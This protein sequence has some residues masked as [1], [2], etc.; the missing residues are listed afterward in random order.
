[1]KKYYSLI[2]ALLL[3]SSTSNMQ[4]Q[5]EFVDLGLPS[6]TLWANMNVGATAEHETGY[7]LAW[8]ETE[9]KADYS[10]ATYK[11]CDG[12]Q[13]IMTKY[14]VDEQYGQVDGKTVLDNEDD[15]GVSGENTGSPTI[16]EFNELMDKNICTWT[17]ETIN[18]RKGARVTGPNGNSIFLPASGFMTNTRLSTDN[19]AGCFWT[20]TLTTTQA[21]YYYNAHVIRVGITRTGISIDSRDHNGAGFVPRN[22]GYNIRPVKRTSGSSGIDNVTADNS[23]PVKYYSITGVE[24]SSP[25]KGLNIAVYSDGSTKKIIVK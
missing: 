19:S 16:E 1:M 5:V 25:S 3:L 23:V 20:N 15:A 22:Y 14:V 2:A 24:T 13:S 11:W 9:P 12:T 7:Y 6:G 8:G 21:R 18:D 17:L 4:A 10:W